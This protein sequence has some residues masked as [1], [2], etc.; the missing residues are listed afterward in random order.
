[1]RWF[2]LFALILSLAPVARAEKGAF[3]VRAGSDTVAVENFERAGDMLTGDL[4]FRMAAL[5]F[6][7]RY[8]P[9]PGGFTELRLGAYTLGAAIDAPPLQTATARFGAD[10]VEVT[11]NGGAPSRLAS[12]ADAVPFLNP[13]FALLESFARA[14]ARSGRASLFMVSG[15]VTMEPGVVRLGG[16]TLRVDLAGQPLLLVVDGTGRLR[17][18]SIPAQHIVVDR[19][20]AP[21]ALAVD[22]PPDYTAPAGAPYTAEEVSIPTPGGF[23]LAGTLTRPAVAR[24][25]VPV[26]LTIT[27]SGQ[28]DRDETIP[29]VRGYRPFRQIA[30]TLARRG[31]AVLRL[32]DRG[33]GGS[34]G[35]VATA[36]SRDFADDVRAALAWLRRRPGIDARRV[37]LLGHSEGG[38]IAPMVAADDR[39]IRA[40]VLMAGPAYDGR[41]VLEYQFGRG[42]SSSANPDSARRAVRAAVDSFVV[43]N[44]WT[45]FF[46]DY[47]PL[48]AARRVQAPVLVLQGA[49]DRQVTAEQG[50][51][52][53]KAFRDGGNRDVTEHVFPDLNHL[54]LPDPSGDP[55]G[56]LTL[57]VR[58]LPPEVLGT[59]VDWLG[60]RL[61]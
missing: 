5:R 47:D 22:G 50:P 7:Y 58:R 59:I 26:V 35:P 32:D 17:G 36:T 15:G 43:A 55:A 54:F 13:S 25:P 11:T 20:D 9:A 41:R 30:D 52:L 23:A 24:G 48:P 33:V 2:V 40:I 46:A 56:Y 27:G 38:L 28:E 6:Q 12:R 3:V 39:A 44:A 1:M 16:D 57:P 31:I 34:G 21:V 29:I 61:R 53:A 4:V 37:A 14:R 18:A 49:T 19:S 8:V 60:A 45:K 51:L 42:V 10:S